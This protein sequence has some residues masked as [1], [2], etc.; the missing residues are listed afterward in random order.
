MCAEV[1]SII[2]ERGLGV[3]SWLNVFSE[4]I[5]KT[6]PF[7]VSYAMSPDSWW[8]AVFTVHIQPR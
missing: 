3:G 8:N 5:R 2:Y 1:H 6:G 7:Y 4:H